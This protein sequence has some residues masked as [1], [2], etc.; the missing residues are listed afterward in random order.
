M[1]TYQNYAF[2]KNLK[3]FF[4]FIVIFFLTFYTTFIHPL[5][6]PDF[7]NYQFLFNNISNNLTKEGGEVLLNTIN[8]FGF[9]YYVF[10]IK[11]FTNSFRFF[12]GLTAF[13]SISIKLFLINK[14]TRNLY[15]ST[16]IYSLLVF[17]I[18][19]LVQIRI[20]LGTSILFLSLYLLEKKSYL[21]SF[22]LFIFSF[23]IHLATLPLVLGALITKSILLVVKNKKIP[24][25]YNIFSFLSVL[26]LFFIALIRYL[27]LSKNLNYYFHYQE[28]SLNIFSIRTLLLLFMVLLGLREFK[29]F[30]DIAKNCFCLSIVG[31]SSYYIFSQNINVS[32]RLMQSVYFTFIIW[33]NYM[34]FKAYIFLRYILLLVSLIF[35]YLIA[36]REFHENFLTLQVDL[37]LI[38]N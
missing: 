12:I 32:S 6:R 22:L 37:A 16:L 23:S 36:F 20:G 18:H 8:G 30:P 28:V 34:P 10:F 24:L 5:N 19:E 14:L 26:S 3:L 33:I 17:P 9:Y 38:F 25:R 13:L 35:V 1:N 15:F 27:S 4:I 11:L 31:L 2:N 7:E 29:N 21:I